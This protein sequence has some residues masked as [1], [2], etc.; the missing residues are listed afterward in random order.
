MTQEEAP[1]TAAAY[2]VPAGVGEGE[3]TVRRS[4]FVA[5]VGRARSRNQALR[6]V[7]DAKE[8]LPGAAHYCWAFNAGAPGSTGQVGASDAGEP[9]GT[10]G[11]SMLAYLLRSGVGEVVAVCARYYGGVKLGTGGLARAYSDSAKQALAACPKKTNIERVTVRVAVPYASVDR[12]ERLWA[13]FGRNRSGEGV[14]HPRSLQGGCPAGAAPA[15]GRRGG[16]RHG[17]NRTRRRARHLTTSA[18][19]TRRRRREGDRRPSRATSPGRESP[20]GDLC[21]KCGS[22]AGST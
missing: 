19:P 18:T 14:R 12:V 11:R 22:T 15:H 7:Q 20:P 4:R 5:R 9:P 16:R 17:G 2:P 1:E 3:S 21:R 6:F 10:A 13:K 8:R